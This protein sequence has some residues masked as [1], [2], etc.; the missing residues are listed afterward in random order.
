VNFYE[1]SL[2]SLVPEDDVKQF[3]ATSLYVDPR[4]IGSEAD[5]W[6]RIASDSP[7]IIGLSVRSAEEGYR[8]FA[9]WVQLWELSPSS[10]LKLASEVAKEFATD[11]AIPDVLD[12]TDFAVGRYLVVSPEGQ[13][14]RG[15]EA[16][17]SAVFEIEELSEA[18]K[19]E[20]NGQVRDSGSRASAGER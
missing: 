17:N 15:I 5:Y 14:R 4:G 12:P 18:E 9:R 1:L 8:T 16:R 11:V 19:L 7:L 3:L 20:S 6:N 2:R 13:T 10:F